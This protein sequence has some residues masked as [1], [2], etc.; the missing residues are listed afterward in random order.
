M[1]APVQALKEYKAIGISNSEK[2]E[3]PF[4][5]LIDGFNV[6]APLVFTIGLDVAPQLTWSAP[7]RDIQVYCFSKDARSMEIGRHHTIT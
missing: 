4:E 1:C 2:I 3:S 5:E 7:Y 6:D